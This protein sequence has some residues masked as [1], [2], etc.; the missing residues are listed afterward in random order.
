[1]VA[2]KKILKS[3]QLSKGVHRRSY[4]ANMKK[5]GKTNRFEPTDTSWEND[6]PE[7]AALF[8]KEGW[9]SFF[10][11]ITGFNLQ[12]SYCFAKGFI[13]DTVTFD[14]LKFELT[15]ELI[16]EATSVS[17]DEKLWFKRI[18]F[19]FNPKDIMLLEIEALDWGKGVHL[20]KF[21]PEWK[22]DIVIL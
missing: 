1:M 4:N 6:F 10:E 21:K 18:P 15:E 13:K 17:R 16:A 7:C 12:V 3:L 20:Y 5:S 14:T 22:E 19:K 11:R 9:F 2:K 8:K